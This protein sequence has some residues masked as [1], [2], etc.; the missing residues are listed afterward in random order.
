MNGTHKTIHN[1]KKQNGKVEKDHSLTKII[2]VLEKQFIPLKLPLE[3]LISGLGV[4]ISDDT[5][6]Q[7]NREEKRILLTN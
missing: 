6:F 4:E 7:Q 5:L 1:Q 3:S 2:S